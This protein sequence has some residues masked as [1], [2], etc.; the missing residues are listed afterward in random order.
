MNPLR[1]ITIRRVA[2]FGAALIVV[3][4]LVAP[5]TL[6]VL[7]LDLPLW[8]G[9]VIGASWGVVGA[10]TALFLGAVVALRE[11]RRNIREEVRRDER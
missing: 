7:L 3:A 9:V 1:R 6:V 4:V 8:L 10:L 5:P 11:A 2:E